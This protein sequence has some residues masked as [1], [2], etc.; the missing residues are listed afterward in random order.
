MLPFRIA[1]LI[2]DVLPYR[3][4]VERAQD[5]ARRLLAHPVHRFPRH[6]R[7]MRRDDHVREFE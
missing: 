6:A 5:V 2:D 3:F 4:A 1:L 7:D